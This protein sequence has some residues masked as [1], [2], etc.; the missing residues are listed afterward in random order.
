MADCE[1]DVTGSFWLI[2]KLIAVTKIAMAQRQKYLSY[3]YDSQEGSGSE[4]WELKGSQD[5][6][7]SS[8]LIGKGRWNVL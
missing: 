7:S 8:L 6:S 1:R 3:T 2:A 5:T 4:I